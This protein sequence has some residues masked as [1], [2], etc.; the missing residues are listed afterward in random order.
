VYSG[1]AEDAKLSNGANMWTTAS[2]EFAGEKETVYKSN[3]FKK[4]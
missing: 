2:F 1:L 3:H 4:P